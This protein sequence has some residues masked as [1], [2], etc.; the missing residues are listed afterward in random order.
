M[1]MLER[2]NVEIAAVMSTWL[3]KALPTAVRK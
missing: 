1:M 2:I 3:E